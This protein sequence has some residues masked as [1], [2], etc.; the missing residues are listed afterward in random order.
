MRW[1]P[2]GGLQKDEGREGDQR[3]LGEGLLRGRETRHGGRVGMYPRR[4]HGTESVG[5]RMCWPYAPTGVQRI[6]DDDDD[7]TKLFNNVNVHS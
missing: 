1:Q 3:P 5:Q 7:T 4:R 6:D 2:W